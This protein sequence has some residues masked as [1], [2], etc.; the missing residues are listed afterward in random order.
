MVH[1]LYWTKEEIKNYANLHQGNTEITKK[2][3]SAVAKR[4]ANIERRNTRAIKDVRGVDIIPLM[5]HQYLHIRQRIVI[6]G[7]I[8]SDID[9]IQIP[10]MIV[11]VISGQGKSR[12]EKANIIAK[13]GIILHLYQHH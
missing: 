12:N 9:M 10:M 1:L 7:D 3:V 8:L 6:V 11:D 2:R 13:D 4:N 5:I